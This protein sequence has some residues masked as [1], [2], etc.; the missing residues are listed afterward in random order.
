M[1]LERWVKTYG[2]AC[3]YEHSALKIYYDF[4]SACLKAYSCFATAINLP[5]NPRGLPL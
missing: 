1:S 2:E 5:D 3:K 4:F